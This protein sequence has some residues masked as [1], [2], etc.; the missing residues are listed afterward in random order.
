MLYFKFITIHFQ[1]KPLQTIMQ[2]ERAVRHT[3]L[4]SNV[5]IN[6]GKST[7]TFCHNGCGRLWI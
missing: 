1:P 6:K 2:K 3:G 5:K 4:F 7:I